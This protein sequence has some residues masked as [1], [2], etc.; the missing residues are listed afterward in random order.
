MIK[1]SKIGSVS[2]VNKYIKSLNKS[3]EAPDD[4]KIKEPIQYVGTVKLHGTNCGVTCKPNGDLFPQSRNREL[5]IKND[6]MGFAIF[7]EKNKDLINGIANDIR[8]LNSIGEQNITIYGE[9]IGPGVQN[10]VAIANLTEKQ[11]VLFAARKS[12]EDH[13][14]LKIDQLKIDKNDF[15][16]SVFDIE[17]MSISIDFTNQ[18]SKEKAIE[19]I[20]NVTETI[21]KKCPWAAQFNIDG[22]GEGVVWM[23]QG[24]YW[25][26]SE[27]M[28]KSKG[29]KHKVTKE[30]KIEKKKEAM[31]PYVL[32]SIEDFVEYSATENRLN[33][34]IDFMKEMQYDIAMENTKHYLKWVAEDISTEC[35]NELIESNLEWKHVAKPINKKALDFWKEKVE[36]L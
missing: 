36:E 11:W 5:S 34:G 27:L 10:K 28:F 19:H 29:D 9:W 26:I 33:Q 3:E 31:D 7:V 30:D 32:K 12:D 18:E 23:P 20:N 21:D 25:G 6:H 13:Q 16:F 2:H 22:P 35:T 24:K 8:E 4:K 15:I 1:F 14:Y 17:T